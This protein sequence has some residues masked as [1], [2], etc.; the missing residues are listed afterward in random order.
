MTCH[1]FAAIIEVWARLIRQYKKRQEQVLRCRLGR[2]GATAGE[3]GEIAED[4]EAA[5]DQFSQIAADLKS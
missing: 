5:L 1:T 4:L 3:L 2:L